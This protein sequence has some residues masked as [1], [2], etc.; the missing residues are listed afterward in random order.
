MELAGERAV[1]MPVPD[2]GAHPGV[3][4]AICTHNRAALL[5]PLVTALRQQ[6]GVGP[7]EILV[8]DSGSTDETPQVLADLS[9]AG[10]P[11]VR[12]SRVPRPGLCA[13]RNAAL[14]MAAG[15]VVAFLDDDAVPRAGWLA[16]LLEPFSDAGVAAVGGR[17]VLRFEGSRPP[18]LTDSLHG[19]LTAF[20]LGPAARR[21]RYTLAMDEYPRGANF[22]VR[23]SAAWDAGSFRLMFERRGEGLRSNDEADLCYRLEGKGWELRYAPA[24]T[25]DHLVLPERFDPQWF[26]RRFAAQGTSD[27][28]F[29]L[30]NRGL[31]A[32]L[33]RVRWYHG[34]RL[35]RRP[36]RVGARPAADRLFAECERRCA[37]GYLRGLALGIPLLRRSTRQESEAP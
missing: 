5:P 34:A 6:E 17:V 36:Y 33:G 19:L 23:R 12:A 29:H 31:R 20:D 22:A 21:V 11:V 13:A 16:A 9:T 35:L 2:P 26:L 27:A 4:I 3:S 18:W 10:S 14:G 37:W 25:V 1:S 8:V 30:S 24:A 28:L 32:A 15:T 7:F